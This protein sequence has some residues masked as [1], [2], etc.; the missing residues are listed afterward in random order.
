MK[1][2]KKL[3]ETGKDSSEL[4]TLWKETF[5]LRRAAVNDSKILGLNVMLQ[6]HCPMLGEFVYVRKKY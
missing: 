6:H 3:F 2:M 1:L 4:K 5:H